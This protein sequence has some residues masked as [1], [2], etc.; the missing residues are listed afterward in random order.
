MHPSITPLNNELIE[1]W[2]H[3][4]KSKNVKFPVSEVRLHQLICLFHF[5]PNAV[6]QDEMDDWMRDFGVKNDRQ[7]RHLAW[8]GWYIQTGNT[9]STRME[10]GAGLNRSQLQLVSVSDANPIW[11]N[12]NERAENISRESPTF[13]RAKKIFAIRGCAVCGTKTTFLEPYSTV[14]SNSYHVDCVPLCNVC[15]DWCEQNQIV[16]VIDSKRI[17]RPLINKIR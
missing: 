9:K 6:S 15:M 12:Y 5:F 10:I 14:E 2:E 1:H 16:L 8:D 4:L 11:L 17:A 7:A 13:V 3:S